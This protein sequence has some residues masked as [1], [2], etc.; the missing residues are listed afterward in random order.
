M[1]VKCLDRQS[2]RKWETS[3]GSSTDLP[4][5]EQLKV[6]LEQRIRTVEALEQSRGKPPSGH[7]PSEPCIK[8]SKMH[9]AFVGEK[10]FSRCGLCKGTRY[11]MFCKHYLSK[12]PQ[13]RKEAVTNCNHCLNCLGSHNIKSYT[14]LKHCRLCSEQHHSSLH[15]A[16]TAPTTAT[17]QL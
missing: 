5:F 10:S 15:D 13:D 1:T 12:S 8:I 9:Q 6:F 7:K 14:S 3:I 11:L 2:R 16:M 4:S 17:V